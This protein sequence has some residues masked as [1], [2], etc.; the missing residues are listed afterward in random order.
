MP[1]SE[2]I[3]VFNTGIGLKEGDPD[4]HWQI[5]ARS[6]QPNFK[7]QPAVVTA[8]GR[9]SPPPFL[10]NVPRRSQWI[11]TA[12][13]LPLLP[14]GVTYTFRT[15]FEMT[16]FQPRTPVLR[17]R[18]IA[19][20]FVI[21][22]RLNGEAAGVPAIDSYDSNYPLE[23]FHPFTINKGFVEGTNILE[24]DVFNGAIAAPATIRGSRRARPPW[25]FSF[26]LEG[27][28]IRSWEAPPANPDH[29]RGEKPQKEVSR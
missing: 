3:Q 18:F 5:V 22:I 21:A 16:A 25:P 29:R 8:V 13:G 7:P 12:N 14:D 26:E 11:S 23:Q 28:A 6:D 2:R 27:S 24:I 15:A 4:P 20:N 17:G 1:K 9:S 19:D 10:E